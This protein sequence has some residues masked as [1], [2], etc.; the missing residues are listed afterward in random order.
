MFQPT[1]GHTEIYCENKH[2]CIGAGSVCP[3]HNEWRCELNESFCFIQERCISN[4]EPTISCGT[5]TYRYNSAPADY[6]LTHQVRYEITDV[7]HKLFMLEEP[8]HV[9]KGDVIGWTG[10]GGEINYSSTQYTNAEFIYPPQNTIGSDFTRDIRPE[11]KHWNHVIS[12]L[13]ASPS[14]FH[15]RHKYPSTGI[16]FITS[17]AT[18][19]TFVFIDSPIQSITFY[20]PEYTFTNKAFH[21]NMTADT[22]SN[23]TYAVTINGT[24]HFLT[25]GEFKYSF[26]TPGVYEVNLTVQNPVSSHSGVCFIKIYDDITDLKFVNPIAPVEL[27]SPTSITWKV[28]RATNVT[29][30]V[31]FGDLQSTSVTDYDDTHVYEL[32]HQYQ[33]HGVYNVTIRATNEIGSLA[34]IMMVTVVDVAV[35]GIKAFTKHHH[36]TKNIYLGTGEVI[37]IEITTTEGT[38]VQCEYTF[39]D[40]SE[41]IVIN[42]LHYRYTY[43][44]PGVYNVTVTCSNAISRATDYVN[45][46]IH[47]E[48]LTSITG[49]FVNASKIFFGEEAKIHG[50]MA[51]GTLFV[52]MWDLGDGTK[53]QVDRSTFND[54]I[55]H[56]YNVVNN[57]IILLKCSN[58]LHT[59]S[60]QY[61]LPIEIPINGFG[62]SCPNQ[63]I[64]VGYEYSFYVSTEKGSR[65][66]YRI[67]FGDGNKTEFISKASKNRTEVFKHRYIKPGT[68][69][70]TVLA[71]NQAGELTASCP[72]KLTVEYPIK[73]LNVYS[74]SPLKF[75][76]NLVIFNYILLPKYH[77]P[78]NLT[79]E[80]DFGDGTKEHEIAVHQN[81]TLKRYHYKEPGVYPVTIIM[82]NKINISK[83]ELQVDIQELIPIKVNI[84]QNTSRILHKDYGDNKN[85]NYFPLGD[86]FII[87]VTSQ[88]KDT[89]Y[90]FDF[91]DMS[92]KTT[93][94][95]PV[96]SHHY[97]IPGVFTV[98]VEVQNQLGVLHG[99]TEI[100]VQEEIHNMNISVTTFVKLGDFIDVN[101]TAVKYGSKLCGIIDFGDGNLTIINRIHCKTFKLNHTDRRISYIST[102]Q[103][104]SIK[105]VYKYK[106]RGLHNVSVFITNKVSNFSAIIPVTV[107]YQPCPNPQ[108]LISGATNITS[109]RQIK[110]LNRLVLQCNVTLD[111]PVAI[112]VTLAWEIFP[113]GSDISIPM[114]ENHGIRNEKMPF[115][116]KPGTLD[117]T[118]LEVDSNVLP[119]GLVKIQLKISYGSR[120]ENLDEISGKD[121]TWF[122]VKSSDLSAEIAGEMFTSFISVLIKFVNFKL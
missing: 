40:S 34:Q 17:N 27:G 23:A 49:L 58:P 93:S 89:S 68:Y 42:E 47:V 37:L 21:V 55:R 61:E 97:K 63:Y 76:D 119:Y 122:D 108:V 12:A 48:E 16:F 57:Y 54:V 95:S 110:R 32:N 9:K 69:S 62:I 102:S 100:D 73:E 113:N 117:P 105:F 44:T 60:Y 6:R 39:G 88:P 41:K 115:E 90:L 7:G 53:F 30:L 79:I 84:H 71:S 26:N 25:N 70:V 28:S 64:P 72:Y 14:R 109:P 74:N 29:Y 107:K 116:R 46:T 18:Q 5:K 120:V 52:C 8:L 13:Y 94:V 51:T 31:D 3:G 24:Y 103:G 67:D 20:C 118:V 91:G 50:T 45:G 35:E 98:N 2:L 56:Q 36:L 81:T 114:K 1:C 101:I 77:F 22:G 75:H 11:L 99:L 4:F 66:S 82:K 111:C 106:T 104:E 87:N 10:Y 59:V 96:V 83:I 121:E 78:T 86:V 19:P 38:N 80:W 112:N 85:H 33:T 43:T 92:P 15:I 65:L